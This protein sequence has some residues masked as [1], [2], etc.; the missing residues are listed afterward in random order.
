MTKDDFIKTINEIEYKNHKKFN[1]EQLVELWNKYKSND[2][3]VFKKI[4]TIP[5]RKNKLEV[6]LNSSSF[7]VNLQDEKPFD[8]VTGEL[9]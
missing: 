5:K 8:I 3:Y 7:Y 9:L 1:K 4:M 2:I 6:N